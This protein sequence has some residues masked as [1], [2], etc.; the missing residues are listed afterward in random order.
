[1]CQTCNTDLV[2]IVQINVPRQKTRYAVQVILLYVIILS[3][4]VGRG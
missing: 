4:F 1:M 3:F 2:K